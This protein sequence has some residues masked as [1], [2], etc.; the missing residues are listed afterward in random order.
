[1]AH[2][3][4]GNQLPVWSGA[5]SSSW[6][7]CLPIPGLASCG[8]QPPRFT[9]LQKFWVLSYQDLVVHGNRWHV[10]SPAG[11][12]WDFSWSF[13]DCVCVCI[14]QCISVPLSEC[15]F[16]KPIWSCQ[17]RLNGNS[18]L[19]PHCSGT[20]LL[21]WA[22]QTL[23]HWCHLLPL[24]PPSNYPETALGFSTFTECLLFQCF[25]NYLDVLCSVFI[26]L[27]ITL[28]ILT[29]ILNLPKLEVS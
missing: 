18:S 19:T 23:C 20:Y 28:E 11:K 6:V 25:Y 26:L 15:C 10:Y 29:Y 27:L 13:C 22:R 16:S 5:S 12:V 21:R 4:D 2:G 8:L 1:M 9:C 3:S 7:L 14:I 24:S 17:T